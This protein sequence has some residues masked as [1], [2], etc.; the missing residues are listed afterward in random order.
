MFIT[1]EADYGIRTVRALSSGQ[2]MNITA[3]CEQENV[4]RQFAY[5]ILKELSRAG[6]VSIIRGVS[7]GYILK[8]DP[9]ELTLY[10]IISVVDQDLFLNK[11]LEPDYDCERDRDLAPCR[12]HRELMRIQTILEEELKKTPVSELI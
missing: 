7:G 6:I 3:I 8:A 12:V 2:K 1:R 11:C 4:P 9:A 5:K 10:D